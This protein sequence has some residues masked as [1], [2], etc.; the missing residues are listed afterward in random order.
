MLYGLLFRLLKGL[1]LGNRKVA[2]HRILTISKVPEIL[3]SQQIILYPPGPEI[4]A[5]ILQEFAIVERQD[6]PELSARRFQ[7]ALVCSNPR[8]SATIVD[9]Y[10]IIPSVADPGPWKIDVGSPTQGGMKYRRNSSILVE[11]RERKAT[12]ERGLFVGSWS[13][14]NWFHWIID[15]LPTV[16]LA[17]RLP[18]Q[19]AD[20]PV[21]L[22]AT[23]SKKSAWLEPLKIVA[24]DR[25]VRFVLEPN[26]YT[27]VSDM[28]FL[29]SPTSPGP[30]S[31]TIPEE[32]SLKVHANAL[33]EYK[34]FIIK[35]LDLGSTVSPER[36]FLARARGGNR[37]YNQDALIEV[38]VSHGFEPIFLEDLSFLDSVKAVASANY[39]VGPHGA[40]WANSL[41]NTRGASA[42]M[43]T[44]SRSPNRN[45][46][47]NITK[48]AG[49][50]SRVIYTDSEA[51]LQ[52][53]GETKSSASHRLPVELFESEL[54]EMLKS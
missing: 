21:L 20:W 50:D 25:P 9:S 42:L 51:S 26:Q 35:S 23:I 1:P 22:P 33:T 36:V 31:Q 38:A 12:I 4:R 13:P 19:L 8:I 29:D 41:F 14:H 48:V 27:R 52:L 47:S 54:A 10:F 43:W 15:T 32:L 7:N 46:F 49:I 24:G 11:T 17:H 34:N 37:P 16:Y 2:G 45:W 40:G 3:L 28:I 39:L 18:N 53:K 44:W 6:Y 5:P 30:I